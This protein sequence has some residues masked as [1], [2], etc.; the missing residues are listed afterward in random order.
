MKE[1]KLFLILLFLGLN[2]YAQKIDK[3]EP[4]YWWADM[5]HHQLEEVPS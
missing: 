2:V 3:I 1:I 5:N 4:P